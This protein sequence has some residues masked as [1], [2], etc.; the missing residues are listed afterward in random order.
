MKCLKQSVSLSE[1]V[2][3]GQLRKYLKRYLK[4]CRPA[5][6]ADPKKDFGRF[7]N[8]AGFC[9]WLGCGISEVDTLRL[10]HPTEADWLNA[11]MEDE[12]INGCAHLSPTL[13]SAYLKRR[14]GYAEKGEAVSGAECGEMR[15][16]FEHDISEDGA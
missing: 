13:L 14:L 9:R 4:S 15:V 10:S 8:L 2:E 1:A 16:I 5:P 6:D 3:N 7:P 12:A 11:V